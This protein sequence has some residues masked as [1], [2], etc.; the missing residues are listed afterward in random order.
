MVAGGADLWRGDGLLPKE[1]ERH[2]RHAAGSR[3]KRRETRGP[4]LTMGLVMPGSRT[5][6][7]P[8]VVRVGPPL[9]PQQFPDWVVDHPGRWRLGFDPI[10]TNRAATNPIPACF[11]GVAH[12]TR[13]RSCEFPDRLGIESLALHAGG[14]C[15]SCGDAYR[16]VLGEH[17]STAPCTYPQLQESQLDRSL[18]MLRHAMATIIL[19]FLCALERLFGQ[20][21]MGSNGLQSLDRKLVVVG[22]GDL[23]KACEQ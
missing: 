4:F 11:V 18:R 23:D 12:G 19:R 13:A 9:R 21:I 8:T 15:K 2:H 20:F 7:L 16:F 3:L 6:S 22:A 14:F 10:T 1:G 17:P 5:N